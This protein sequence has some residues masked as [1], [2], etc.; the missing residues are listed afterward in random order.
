MGVVYKARYLKLNRLVAIKFLSPDLTLDPAASARFIREARI[1]S[2]LNHPNICVIHEISEFESQHFMV[3]EFVDGET[4]RAILKRRGSLS[5]PEVLELGIKVADA[6]QTAHAKDI[7]HRDIKP[8]NIMI[9]REGFV[10]VMD[11][12]LAK[13]R[14]KENIV[15]REQE[16]PDFTSVPGDVAHDTSTSLYGTM[17]YMSPE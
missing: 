15:R 7:I 2:A 10:K 4:L 14:E 17:A 12:G 16:I 13:L 9:S 5:V 8:D 6:L 1:I 3:M 11:F